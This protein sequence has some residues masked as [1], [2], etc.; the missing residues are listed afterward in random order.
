MSSTAADGG[1]KKQAKKPETSPDGTRWRECH[2]E[3]VLIGPSRC[4]VWQAHDETT[5]T[6]RPRTCSAS[7]LSLLGRSRTLHGFLCEYRTAI[8]PVFLVCFPGISLITEQHSIHQTT[9]HLSGDVKQHQV[10]DVYFIEVGD[11]TRL[12]RRMNLRYSAA[13]AD[14]A[15]I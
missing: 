6:V 3:C 5:H 15:A 14:E 8:A 4:S 13:A 1:Q 11:T 2:K 9:P 10:S 12:F 7:S